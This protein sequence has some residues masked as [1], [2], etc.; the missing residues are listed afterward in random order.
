MKTNA[1]QYLL[2]AGAVSLAGCD[3]GP[4]G[5]VGFSL[6]DG[7]VE[8]G[9]ANYVTFQCHVCHTTD[10]VPQ[11]ESDRPASISVTLGG[12]TTKIKTYGELVTSII[13]PSH[14]ITRRTSPDMAN[15]GGE[16]KMV[17][18]NDFMTVTQL[19][20]L[21]AFVQSNYTLSPYNQSNYPVYWIP[22]RNQEK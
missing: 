21:V 7:D 13:N 15:P 16:S 2:L 20:D 6:P 11:L 19:I 12:E 22:E 18:F 1:L 17:S 4:K 3:T 14:K 9:R 5:A 8:A 10:S